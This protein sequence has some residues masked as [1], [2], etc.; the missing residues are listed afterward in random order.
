MCGVGS[1]RL[2]VHPRLAMK[3]A[4][5]RYFGPG[6]GEDGRFAATAKTVL[7]PCLDGRE[8]RSLEEIVQ[9]FSEHDGHLVSE[10]PPNDEIECS[11]P[12]SSRLV[13]VETSQLRVE[14]RGRRCGV[15]LE[16][17]SRE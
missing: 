13:V 3:S 14:I 2:C 5:E 16:K 15:L 12:V 1:R 6:Q 9:G 4:P 8:P 10:A 7:A 11:I 17:R